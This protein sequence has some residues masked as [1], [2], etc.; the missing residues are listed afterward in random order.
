MGELIHEPHD[1]PRGKAGRRRPNSDAR[2]GIRRRLAGLVD[3][4]ASWAGG[5]TLGSII[6]SAYRAMHRAHAEPV[7]PLPVAAVRPTPIERPSPRSG[8]S[9][10]SGG[11]HK[12]L[13]KKHERKGK[14]DMSAEE[15]K[16][17]IREVIEEVW[18]KG[19]LAAVDRYFAPH[20]VDHA[21]LPG[22]APGPEGYKGAVAAIRE[23]FPDLRLT[24]EDILGER[25]KVAFRYTMEGTHRGDFMGMPRPVSRFRSGDDLRPDRRRQGGGALGQPGHPGSDAAAWRRPFPGGGPGIGKD[26]IT[27][28]V[29]EGCGPGVVEPRPFLLPLPASCREWA[30]LE[31]SAASRTW[32]SYLES[33]TLR[34]HNASATAPP[35]TATSAPLNTHRIRCT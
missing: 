1:E 25:D 34:T 33:A 18:N 22:Q 7:R 31:T 16:A 19:D 9:P 29:T 26:P 8:R 10:Q 20:Y 14:P 32:A 13:R 2:A 17:L 35:A 5:R 15:N 23:A 24:L 27:R 6:A 30:L 28:I 12:E 21:P 3:W 11:E 4:Q